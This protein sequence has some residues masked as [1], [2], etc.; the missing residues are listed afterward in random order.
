MQRN[1]RWFQFLAGKTVAVAAGCLIVVAAVYL[2]YRSSY[3]R[4]PESLSINN[5]LVFTFLFVLA[6]LIAGLLFRNIVQMVFVSLLLKN[7]V[8]SAGPDL[9]INQSALQKPVVRGLEILVSVSVWGLFL[10][11]FHSFFTAVSWILGGR[12]LY[13][14]SLS[15]SMIEGTETIL[16]ISF[17]FALAMFLVMFSWAQWNYWRFG[18]LERRKPRPPVP[19][20]VIAAQYGIPE[21]IVHKATT[22]KVARILTQEVGLD[23]EVIKEM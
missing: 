4:F 1:E 19:C 8:L 7:E 6:A 20:S 2:G 22:V 11:F 14:D 3:I 13:G 15:P 17:L 10:Y 18:R 9:V 12:L 23:L 16:L 21:R 5:I